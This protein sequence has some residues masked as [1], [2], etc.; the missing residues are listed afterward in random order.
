[1]CMR[2]SYKIYCWTISVETQRQN[3]F[4][5]DILS[6]ALAETIMA[7]A[8]GSQLIARGADNPIRIRDIGANSV[9]SPQS[10]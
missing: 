10:T 8:L 4:R 7:M 6:R 1:M 9:K 5:K 2:M 3:I